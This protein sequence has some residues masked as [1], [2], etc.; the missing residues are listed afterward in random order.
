[1][2]R[3]EIPKELKLETYERRKFSATMDHLGLTVELIPGSEGNGAIVKGFIDAIALHDDMVKNVEDNTL[4]LKNIRRE[5]TKKNRM[6]RNLDG[7]WNTFMSDH[8]EDF[9][10]YKALAPNMEGMEERIK[11]ITDAKA[12]IKAEADWKR[13]KELEPVCDKL[14]EVQDALENAREERDVVQ[15]RLLEVEGAL[16]RS[17]T[18]EKRL[19]DNITDDHII[20]C[21][22]GK[23]IAH[24][25]PNIQGNYTLYSLNAKYT[26]TLEFREIK[27][28]IKKEKPPH[29]VIFCRYDYRF[30]PFYDVWRSL[31]ELRDMGVCIDDPMM[32][33]A[34]FVSLAATGDFQAV[35]EV[36]LRGEDP[37]S[38]DYTGATALHA[39]AANKHQDIIELLARAGARPDPRDKNQLT[40]MLTAVMKG[41]LSA[42]RQLIELGCD[43]DARDKNQ[44]N[45]LYFAMTSGNANM[46]NFFV[47]ETNVNDSEELWGFTPMHT[48][49]NL[50]NCALIKQLLTYNGSIYK[51]DHQKRTAE[52]IARECN[53]LDCVDLLEFER[54]HAPAQ[55]CFQHRETNLYI[56][57]G[58]YGALD[59]VWST[60]VGITEVITL[61]TSL[62]KPSNADWLI[63][64]HTCK[65]FTILIDADDDDDTDGSF[66]EFRATLT[67]VL[68]HILDL[69]KKGDAE[70]LLCDPS[71]LSTAPA[72]L[73]VAL[74]L[75]YQIPIT[76]SLGAIA[77][78]RPALKMSKSLRRGLETIQAEFNDKKLKRLDAKIRH[79]KV[80]SNAF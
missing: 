51:K 63:D 75:R 36:L 55:L 78:A 61:T 38:M 11:L 46:V 79:A 70:I 80:I 72:V 45:A 20:A 62:K 52:D 1:M 23:N 34:E 41:H 16:A 22:Q 77:V 56:W 10:E 74:L 12:K 9:E 39:A 26:E 29:N 2:Q 25:F 65:H 19:A 18:E 32:S 59:P 48:A 69:M 8:Q 40:P 37:N 31:N 15:A 64:D 67:T 66:I 73:A 28:L 71:G 17:K 44:R 54:Y 3:L 24:I 4:A 5:F 58:E 60:D 53:Y 57:V 30:D 6:Y 35:K 33:K 21:E 13:F 27:N 76:K 43:R 68:S 50:G 42:V 49:A 14:K 7:A 47:N